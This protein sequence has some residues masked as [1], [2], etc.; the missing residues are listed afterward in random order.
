MFYFKLVVDLHQ[1]WAKAL[2]PGDVPKLRLVLAGGSQ[3][4]YDYIA[5]VNE[6]GHR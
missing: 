1:N 5:I 4:S 3:I 2:L 6:D